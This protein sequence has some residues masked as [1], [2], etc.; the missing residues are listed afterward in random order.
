MSEM[1]PAQAAFREG[2]SRLG[3][4]VNVITTAGPGGWYGMTATSVCSVTDSPPTLLVCI[5]Q[6]ARSHDMFVENGILCVNV[7]AGAHEELSGRFARLGDEDRFAAT[8]WRQGLTGAPVLE[9]ALTAFDCNIV[10]RLVRGTHSIFI[11]EVA[12]TLNGSDK[13]GLLWFGRRYHRLQ[14]A[15]G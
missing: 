9:G 3:A 7:L 13:E 8:S 10:D 5:N 15:D 12:Q 14:Q 4:A 11:C 1:S 6:S 2:M